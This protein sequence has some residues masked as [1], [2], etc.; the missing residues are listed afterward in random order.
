MDVVLGARIFQAVF[1]RGMPLQKLWKEERRALLGLTLAWVLRQVARSVSVH[2][3]VLLCVTVDEI[4]LMPEKLLSSV[5]Q[6]LGDAMVTCDHPVM[7]VMAGLN[8]V[9][10]GDA[11]R[12]STHPHK[13]LELG[14]FD[15][16]TRQQ[17]LTNL[18]DEE[19]WWARGATTAKRAAALRM[20]AT[21]HQDSPLLQALVRDTSGH[22]RMMSLL[23]EAVVEY[24]V[25]QS[26]VEH[27]GA[28]NT[29]KVQRTWHQELLNRARNNSTKYAMGDGFTSSELVRLMATALGNIPVMPELVLA[30]SMTVEQLQQNGVLYYNPHTTDASSVGIRIPFLLMRVWVDKVHSL[31]QRSV[32]YPEE[33]CAKAM[34]DFV[35]SLRRWFKLEDSAFSPGTRAWT[36][37]GAAGAI[38]C[39]LRTNAL[40]VFHRSNEVTVQ[41]SEFHQGA[42][43]SQRL[44]DAKLRIVLQPAR[45]V[46]VREKLEWESGSPGG[47]FSVR[48]FQ[49][50]GR[51]TVKF[52]P[53]FPVLLDGDGGAGLDILIIRP[54]GKEPDHG[55]GVGCE[56]EAKG[57][58]MVLEMDQRKA[59]SAATALSLKAVAAQLP[60]VGIEHCGVRGQVVVAL[61]CTSDLGTKSIKTPA[62]LQTAWDTACGDTCTSPFVVLVCRRH[63]EA[64]M[65]P[66]LATRQVVGPEE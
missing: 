48:D 59:Y 54:D 29:S 16:I 26:L 64:Y 10:I 45:Y 37:W 31:W 47:T 35:W 20:I 51:R 57:A 55:G 49:D 25:K 18:Q 40:C 8:P 50:Q 53:P 60:K 43:L 28:M 33:A 56:D 61:H 23:V 58:E 63:L 6:Q 11:I 66:M 1:A 14:W 44:V 4:Q 42:L 27:L 52:E 21:Q 32:E 13:R 12:P 22:P 65:G 9:A 34:V 39:C 30:A 46:Q 24:L 15:N 38:F 36:I 3:D 19:A 7:C 5:F 17:F 2:D 41:L 62:D